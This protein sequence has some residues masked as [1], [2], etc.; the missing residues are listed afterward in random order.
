MK[1]IKKKNQKIG[2]KVQSMNEIHTGNIRGVRTPTKKK[3]EKK[4]IQ[5]T[6]I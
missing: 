2:M 6:R 5:E 4:K 3:N 1:K